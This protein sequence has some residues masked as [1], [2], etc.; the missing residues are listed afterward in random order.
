MRLMWP[1]GKMSLTPLIYSQAELLSLVSRHLTSRKGRT[2]PAPTSFRIASTTPPHP[3]G[4]L[5]KT[6]RTEPPSGCIS[7]RERQKRRM[8]KGPVL[9]LSQ[10]DKI[11]WFLGLFH[12]GQRN[13]EI[14]NE[15]NKGKSGPNPT[16]AGTQNCHQHQTGKSWPSGTDWHLPWNR[17]LVHQKLYWK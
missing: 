5:W 12:W 6:R 4:K 16:S 13:R 11:C 2:H 14:R 1:P 3:T 17:Q 8:P 15:C 7:A 10:A 9:N